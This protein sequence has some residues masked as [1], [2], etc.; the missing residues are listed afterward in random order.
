LLG[1]IL[2]IVLLL[3]GVFAAVVFLIWLVQERFVFFPPGTSEMQEHRAE[4][5]DFKSTDDQP[6]FGLFVPGNSPR[7]L[8]LHFHGNGDLAHNWIDWAHQ[9]AQRTGWSV[10]LAEYRGYGGLPGRPTYD[11]VMHDSR[12]TLALLQ[13]RYGVLPNDI[14]LYGHSLGTGV[15]AQLAAEQGARTVLL[16]APL[17]SI[18]D[19]GQRSFIPPFSYVVPWISRIH[20]APVDDVR[21]IQSPVW[22]TCGDCD[23]VCPASMSEEVYAA[24]LHKGEYLLVPTAEHGNVVD[25]GGEKYWEWLRRALKAA[26]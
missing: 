15:A 23:V 16:E 19:A 26:Q 10:F 24:A 20:W 8:I 25:V 2:R 5:V 11:G 12:A 1:S 22:V 13:E 14:V 3:S 18:I 17:T 6:L 7:R 21:K 9:I 4:R